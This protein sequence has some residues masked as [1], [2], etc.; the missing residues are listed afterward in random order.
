VPEQSSTFTAIIAALAAM[1]GSIVATVGGSYVKGSGDLQIAIENSKAA[2]ELARAKFNSDLVMK[3]LEAND[4]EERLRTLQLLSETHLITDLDV[5]AAIS[6]Y[7]SD[8]QNSPAAVPQI[9]ASANTL[10]PPAPII[11]N[12]RIY[13]LAGSVQK[14]V[15]FQSLSR[16]FSSAFYKVQEARTIN[17]NTRPD[18]PEVRYFNDEDAQQARQVA[19]YV[20]EQIGVAD[21]PA[22]K[23]DDAAAKPGYLEVWLGR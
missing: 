1:V 11:A 15:S 23:Y 20:Q 5:R 13:L 21:V 17:D 18:T 4:P 3:A 14:S 19:D 6:K 12:V 22:K 10:P 8:R 2:A 7:A 9:Q 16:Q